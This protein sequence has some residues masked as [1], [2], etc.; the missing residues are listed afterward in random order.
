MI[1]RIPKFL[2][3]LF[4]R[5]AH[6][7]RKNRINIPSKAFLT[8]NLV[9]SWNKECGIATYT[10]FLA[11]ELRK[12]AGIYVTVVPKVH[13]LNP[14][15]KILGYR[16]GRSRDLVH[17]QFEYGIFPSLKMGKKTLTAFSALHFY[18]GLAMGNRR[19][20]TTIHEPRKTVTT[21]WA[22]GFY[23]KL[24]DRLIFSTS[25]LIVVHTEESK[26]LMETLYGVES[27]K[28]QVIPHG[29]YEQPIFLSKEQAK[30]KFGLQGKIV[31]AI[32]G[33]VTPKKGHD[34][35][36]PLL[37]QI[38]KNVQLVIAGGPQNLQDELYLKTLK[39][40]SNQYNCLDRVTFTGFL[41]DLG[42]I[43]NATDVAIVPYRYVTDSG[44]LH[45]LMAYK[46]PTLASDL[47]AF[48]EVYAEYGCLE[49]FKSN[50]PKDLYLKLQILL[51]DNQ[52]REA[53]KTKC[54]D[55]WNATKWSTI[56]QRH[57]DI[58]RKVLSAGT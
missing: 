40:L 35:V 11:E 47:D 5:T 7:K 33:F 19:V 6:N 22:S 12:E 29:S 54:W 36:I 10:H 8:I 34:L 1:K 39:E 51:S 48:K 57:I 24:L 30:A 46:V 45:L 26:R 43:L 2:G 25:D 9:T 15:F 58:Y 28:L 52:R 42:E 4:L 20:V 17:V 49:L 16:V 18:V 50:D 41:P 13:A 21:G 3:N 23:T 38:D 14:Y 27:S 55:M 53:L 37:P 44:V 31:V 32:L 56:A